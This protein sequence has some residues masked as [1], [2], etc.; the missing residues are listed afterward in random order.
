[1]CMYQ[2]SAL[3]PIFAV[4]LDEI[5]RSIQGNVPWL[6]AYDIVLVDMKG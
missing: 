2:G 3:S 5:T 4:I 1:M 6:F